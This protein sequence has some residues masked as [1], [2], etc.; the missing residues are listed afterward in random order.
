MRPV[1]RIV[2]T[3]ADVYWGVPK[4]VFKLS[5]PNIA[6]PKPKPKPKPYSGTET[7]SSTAS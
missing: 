3:Y 5:K 6:K 1:T 7:N 2:A 4:N